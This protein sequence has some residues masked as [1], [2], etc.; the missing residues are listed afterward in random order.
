MQRHRTDSRRPAK[1]GPTG[2]YYSC[3]A[4]RITSGE[5][6]VLLVGGRL[7]QR[8]RSGGDLVLGVHSG[9]RKRTPDWSLLRWRLECRRDLDPSWAL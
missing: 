2:T 1:R 3:S 7:A 9:A 8:G 5:L 4:S 6:V